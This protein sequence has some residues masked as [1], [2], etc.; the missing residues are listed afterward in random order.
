MGLALVIQFAHGEPKVA[1]TRLKMFL[2]SRRYALA[3]MLHP[4][5]ASSANTLFVLPPPAHNARTNKTH[6]GVG[7]MRLLSKVH[8]FCFGC[9]S[10]NDRPPQIQ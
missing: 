3:L 9:S 2:K 6:G 5:L 8:D 7:I 4:M 1:F 10:G